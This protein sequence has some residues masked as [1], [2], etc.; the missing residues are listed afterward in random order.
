MP[1]FALKNRR[2][3]EREWDTIRA[4]GDCLRHRHAL[5]HDHAHQHAH[6]LLVHAWHHQQLNGVNPL[7]TPPL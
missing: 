1:R 4:V 5:Y 6:V 3:S 7:S 2:G